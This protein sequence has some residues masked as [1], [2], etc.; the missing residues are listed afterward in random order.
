MIHL[1]SEGGYA[2]V[3]PV[4]AS[5]VE[6]VEGAK[7]LISIDIDDC[8]CPIC[9]EDRGALEIYTTMSMRLVHN[10]TVITQRITT[11]EAISIAKTLMD[12]ANVLVELAEEFGS[13]KLVEMD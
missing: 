8:C 5:T 3:A 11:T 10:N 4:F 6:E 2:C 13:E 12:Y 7:Q 1:K 9:E